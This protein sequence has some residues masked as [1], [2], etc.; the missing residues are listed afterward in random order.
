M[1]STAMVTT[2]MPTTVTTTNL[3]WRYDIVSQTTHHNI[4]NLPGHWRV[5]TYVKSSHVMEVASFPGSL[6]TPTKRRKEGESLVKLKQNND[7]Q[8]QKDST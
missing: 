5:G 3:Q 6:R 7:T 4:H 1:S 2:A 8:T